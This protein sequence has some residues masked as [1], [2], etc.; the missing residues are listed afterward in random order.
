MP[1]SGVGRACF[2]TKILITTK[3]E[4]IAQAKFK[5]T[6]KDT[7]NK[8]SKKL[9]SIIEINDAILPQLDFKEVSDDILS[10]DTASENRTLLK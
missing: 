6:T 2:L 9:D 4:I 8:L 5:V 7:E 1:Y 10:I 3:L